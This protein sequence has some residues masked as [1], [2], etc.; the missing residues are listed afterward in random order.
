MAVEPVWVL[1]RAVFAIHQRQIAEHGG[2]AGVRDAGLL[3]SALNRPKNLFYYSEVQ[4]TRPA[5]AAAYAYGIACNHPF[6]DGNKRTAF[7]VCETFLK[8]N[9]LAVVAT[10]Q[11][12]YETFMALAAGRLSENELKSWLETHTSE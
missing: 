6:V 7:V 5:L 4:P 1:E 12:K 9:G 8:L 2:S 11:E 10:Q 3:D